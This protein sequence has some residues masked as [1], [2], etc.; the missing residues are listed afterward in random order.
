MP[1]L[2]LLLRYSALPYSA[3]PEAVTRVVPYHTVPALRLLLGYSALP[4][5]AC[6]KLLHRYSALP[7]SAC[8]EAVAQ[9][10]CLVQVLCEHRR[11]QAIDSLVRPFDHFIQTFKADDLL[12]RTKDL[13]EKEMFVL[14]AQGS[15]IV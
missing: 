14:A 12:D 11:G 15:G 10:Q 6:L 4:Y 13:Q 1:T 9:V 2:R 3:C 8:P 5:S 7:Y